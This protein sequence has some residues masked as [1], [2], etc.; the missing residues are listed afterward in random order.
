MIGLKKCSVSA[1]ILTVCVCAFHFNAHSNTKVY[2][3]LCSFHC[4]CAVLSDDVVRLTT[5]MHVNV[6][7]DSGYNK[8]K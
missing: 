6:S 1:F 4:V 8:I 2:L 7:G 3:T 5:Q